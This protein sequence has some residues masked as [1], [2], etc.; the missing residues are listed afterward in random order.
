MNSLT[1]SWAGYLSLALFVF[2]YLLVIVE[3][4]LHLRKSKPVLLAGCLM[5]AFIA[6]YVSRLLPARA[7]VFYP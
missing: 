3:D 2:A 5:W 1:N 6:L 7:E 4:R